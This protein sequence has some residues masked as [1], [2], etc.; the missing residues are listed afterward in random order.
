VS[1]LLNKLKRP[2]KFTLYFCSLILI[3][4]LTGCASD[5]PPEIKTAPQNSPTVSMARADSGRFVGDLVRWGGVI[6]KVENRQN[7]T[8]IEIVARE[9]DSSGR[10]RDGDFS[11]GRFIAVLPGFLDPAVYAKARAITVSGILEG[12]INQL[13]GQHSYSYLKVLADSHVLWKPIPRNNS[14]NYGYPYSGS[15][16]WYRPGPYRHYHHY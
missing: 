6:A 14:Y 16:M 13:I 9:L 5:I 4:S 12:S 10:P 8:W 7:Q 11:P 15:Y 1:G 2:P 3:I